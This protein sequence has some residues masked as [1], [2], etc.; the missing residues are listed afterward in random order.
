MRLFVASPL[1]VGEAGGSLEAGLAFSDRGT[2]RMGADALKAARLDPQALR[3][4]LWEQ[5]SL[6]PIPGGDRSI[7]HGADLCLAQL[8]QRAFPNDRPWAV[9]VPATWEHDQLRIFL[10]I[11]K[12]VEWTVRWVMPRALA[13]A[14]LADPGAE[15]LTV[16]EWAWTHLS[17][18]E[19]F[20]EEGA[21]RLRRQNKFA[22]AGLFKLFRREADAANEVHLRQTRSDLMN[23]A[24]DEQKLFDAWWRWHHAGESWK[25]GSLVLDEAAPYAKLHAAALPGLA[26]YDVPGTLLPPALRHILGFSNARSD[27]VDLR[28][29]LDAVPEND[30]GRTRLIDQVVPPARVPPPLPLPVTHWV[31]N[32]IAEAVEGEAAALPGQSVT[33]SDGRKALAI[34]VPR[35]GG[36]P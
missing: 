26:K 25:G 29:I 2:W 15:T 11:A 14:A 3:A 19:M 22:E 8:R 20:R 17:V 21:W 31:V 16:F 28:G 33:L 36:T 5:P 30:G 24:A 18:C 6:Q 12:E 27:E 34:H 7:R 23:L 13:V 1:G 4:D 32:G 9:L 10:G 35:F